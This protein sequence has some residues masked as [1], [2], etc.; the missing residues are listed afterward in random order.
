M[1]GEMWLLRCAVECMLE[2]LHPSRAD[3]VAYLLRSRAFDPQRAP[4]LE[5]GI[6]AYLAGD[7]IVAV[8]VLIPQIENALRRIVASTHDPKEAATYALTT[9]AE[10]GMMLKTCERLLREAAVVRALTKDTA[11]YFEV[12]FTDQRG[13][14]LRN[15]V[16]HGI[17][18]AEQFGLS[19]ADRVFH[20]LLVLQRA[21]AATV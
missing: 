17:V 14:N 5:R 13:W 1:Q 3:L 2:R 11:R 19:M 15:N 8:P 10:G 21:G 20:A 9:N 18:P 16:C 6:D 4:I 7:A 12:L